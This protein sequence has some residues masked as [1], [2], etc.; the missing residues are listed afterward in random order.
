MTVYCIFVYLTFQDKNKRFDLASYRPTEREPTST[1]GRTAFPV[2]AEI[3]APTL[4]ILPSPYHPLCSQFPGRSKSFYIKTKASCNERRRS[5]CF[6]TRSYTPSEAKSKIAE[7]SWQPHF[8]RGQRDYYGLS[9]Y[10][11]HRL[12]SSDQR[13]VLDEADRLT[14]GSGI[15]NFV[16]IRT[17]LCH[18][19]REKG[20]EVARRVAFEVLA[21]LLYRI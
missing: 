5:V 7:L 12:R 9:Q 19:P 6:S 3:P 21:Q 14:F 15:V 2:I 10:P 8:W 18:G 13:A 16:V 4:Q 17:R 20:F 1:F 11:Y